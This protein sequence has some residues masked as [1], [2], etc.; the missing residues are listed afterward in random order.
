MKKLFAV[1]ATL[2]SLFVA[3]NAFAADIEIKDAWAKASIGQVRNGAAF[4]VVMNHGGA[5]RIVGVRSDLADKTEL[6]T[7]IMENNVMKMRE[8]Q[9]GVEVPMHGEVLFKPGSYHVMFIGLHN[10]LKEG[11]MINITLELEKGGD[12]PVVIEVKNAMSKGMSGMKHGK[13]HDHG[14]KDHNSH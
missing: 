13:G 1:I 11:D 5:D 3:G 6:H 14:K 7:H 2:A 8:V 9:G 4:F 10:P 12:L